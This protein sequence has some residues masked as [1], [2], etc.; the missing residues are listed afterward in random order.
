MSDLFQLDVFRLLD[1][2]HGNKQKKQRKQ[3]LTN[4]K[5]LSFCVSAV[6]GFYHV[7]NVKLED[8][9]SLSF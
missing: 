1:A 3:K 4:A 9:A 2:V 7:R 8:S 5:M 6:V